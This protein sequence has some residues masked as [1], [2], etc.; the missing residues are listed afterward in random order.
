[1]DRVAG[2]PLEPLNMWQVP[3]R[4]QPLP[5]DDDPVGSQIPMSQIPP[6]RFSF[7]NCAT[8]NSQPS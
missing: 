6:V 3:G 4:N 2:V 7:P 1:M 8:A 5:D